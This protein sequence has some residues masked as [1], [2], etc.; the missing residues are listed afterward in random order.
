[1]SSN[2]SKSLDILGVKPVADAV[3]VV[4]KGTVAGAAAFLGRIC[5]PAAEEIGLLLR[6]KVRAWR[7]TNAAAIASKA[8][9]ILE[10]TSDVT[11]HAHPRLVG[12]ILEEGSWIDVDEVQQMWAGLLVSSCTDDGQDDSNLMFADLLS[13]LTTS[14]VRILEHACANARKEVSPGGL[15]SSDHYIINLEE[16]R[17]ISKVEDLHRLDREL[18]HLRSLGLINPMHGGF[19]PETIEVN[20]TPTALALQMYTRCNG[21]RSN[22]IEFFGLSTSVG[23]GLGAA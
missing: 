21:K 16:L 13:R 2:D 17:A 19:D 1:M 3:H 5:L 4:T 6:D 10:P 8:E 23:G 12:L 7:A 11:V 22:P 15:I 20:L 9:V 14:Q 18:D